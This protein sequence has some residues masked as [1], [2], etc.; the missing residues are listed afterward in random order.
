MPL[1]HPRGLSEAS[2]QDRNNNQ[3]HVCSQFI[4][5]KGLVRERSS[6]KA[7]GLK[8]GTPEQSDRVFKA[9]VGHKEGSLRAGV[10]GGKGMER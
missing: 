1:G 8:L 4:N 2:G 3:S 6:S 9:A 7:S 10:S 5:S